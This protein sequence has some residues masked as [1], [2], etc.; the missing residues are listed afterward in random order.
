VLQAQAPAPQIP[1]P[2]GGWPIGTFQQPAASPLRLVEV[3]LAILVVF[4]GTLAILATILQRRR[5]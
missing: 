4:L 3:G 2:E 1:E 5:R